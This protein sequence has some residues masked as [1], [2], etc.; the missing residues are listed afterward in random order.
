MLVVGLVTLAG[1]AIQYS[2]LELNT[3]STVGDLWATAF[4]AGF[5]ATIANIGVSVKE[6]TN[7]AFTCSIY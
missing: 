7:F 2:E 6:G 5:M 3:S 1:S 4:I